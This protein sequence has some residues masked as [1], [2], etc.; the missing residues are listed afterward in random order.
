MFSDT[1]AAIA[2]A[3]G[4]G[5]VS[6]I[7]ISGPD[8]LADL[9]AVFDH[10]LFD[11]A[12]YTIH[13]G[14]VLEQGKPVDEVL[15]SV[16]RAPRSYTGEDVMELSCH[17]GVYITRKILSLILGTG[18][19]LA[20]RGEFTER[21][22]LNGKMDLS[23][24]EGVNDLIVARDGINAASAV[25]SLSGSVRKLLEPLVEE[26]VQII[27]HIEVNIDYPEYDD[28]VQLRD[29]DILPHSEQWLSR[30]DALIEQ[31]QQ[32]VLIRSGIDTVILGRPNVGKSSLLNALL[33]E[34][35][36]IVTDI[37]GTTRDLVEGSVRLGN[38]TLNLI[39][40]AGIRQASD[41]I[42][43][44]GIEK[45]LQALKK[46]QLAIVVLDSSA[47]ITEEDQKLL[48]LTKD[49]D[50]IVVYN[51]KDKK[52]IPDTIAVSAIQKDVTELVHA[53][54]EKYKDEITAASGDTLNNERQ[55]GLAIQARASMV[56]VIRSLK[57]G[58]P[59]DL[60]TIDL[61]N[62]YDA[63]KEITGEST[64]EGLLDEIFSR[65]CLGK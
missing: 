6:I 28:V 59:L 50:R 42:E 16:F 17:G 45:S 27:S 43:Q 35:K 54:E 56:E 32:A 44:I 22:F 23:Q 57:E 12:G 25:H 34:D 58:T 55:I 4:T 63:L 10:D 64:R 48:D 37:P 31:A 40:T 5:A 21:A 39:D 51:K 36:A 8:A 19:R 20:R 38:V 18:A 60:V 9:N 41:Q 3:P 61:Q 46:A 49:K 53:I 33:E 65:F 13:H 2:T 30:I 47:G 14:M 26:I 1:I 24:A 11:A 15:V 7:R 29:E 62:A 52:E